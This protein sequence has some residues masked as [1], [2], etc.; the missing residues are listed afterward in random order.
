MNP[1]RDGKTKPT[2]QILCCIHHPCWFSFTK[3]AITLSPAAVANH[4]AN[5][6]GALSS[7]RDR[8]SSVA[9]VVSKASRGLVFASHTPTVGRTLDTSRVAFAVFLHAC[10]LSTLATQLVRQDSGRD[11]ID[12]DPP[13]GHWALWGRRGGS[14]G[15]VDWTP[16]RARRV[17]SPLVLLKLGLK[18]RGVARQDC[19]DGVLSFRFELHRVVAI[20]A[21]AIGPA[22]N[23]DCK[24]LT[25]QFETLGLFARAA[26]RCH[27]LAVI[28]F[29]LRR[30]G[31]PL[32]PG[33]QLEELRRHVIAG[34]STRPEDSGPGV[35]N[36]RRRRY[37][38]GGRT[39]GSGA[40]CPPAAAS[41]VGGGPVRLLRGE[42]G[43]GLPT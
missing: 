35:V 39:F 19:P 22:V 18:G 28:V 6:I 3:A 24:A 27:L 25:I 36:R 13:E 29:D 31:G 23:L 37:G 20:H 9:G 15:T 38:R 8:S 26:H 5:H 41:R 32:A 34:R 16:D 2:Y 21:A 10:R 30:R 1:K 14:I 4:F 42:A 33:L 17:R 12:D 43:Q 40:P 11:G 7:R